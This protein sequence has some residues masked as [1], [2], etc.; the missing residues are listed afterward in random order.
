ME[1]NYGTCYT[2]SYMEVAS[3]TWIMIGVVLLETVSNAVVVIRE[4]EKPFSTQSGH[5]L[6]WSCV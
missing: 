4:P 2:F 6:G 1:S 3:G 5:F